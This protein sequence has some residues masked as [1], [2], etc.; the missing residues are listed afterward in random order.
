MP[1]VLVAQEDHPDERSGRPQNPRQDP[2]SR[3]TCADF[4][5]TEELVIA[6]GMD[7]TALRYCATT[8]RKS[9]AGQQ[10]PRPNECTAAR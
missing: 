2:P 6:P 4:A 5:P 3:C 1:A 8:W 10:L 7:A 9:A